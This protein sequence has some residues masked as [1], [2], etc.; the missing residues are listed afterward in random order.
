MMILRAILF[1]ILCILMVA[2][3]M[4]FKLIDI[5]SGN[6]SLPQSHKRRP[7]L[8][9]KLFLTQNRPKY[10][11][12]SNQ[13]SLPTTPSQRPVHIVIFTVWVGERLHEAKSNH[14]LYAKKLG[15]DYMHIFATPDEYAA[16]LGGS[17]LGWASVFVAQKLL[18]QLPSVD[19]FLKMDQ[20]CVFARAD[21]PIETI[22]D[23]REQ[24]HL[25]VS[26]TLP[27]SRFT[28]SHTWLIR[29]SA[30]S[31]DFLREWL[32]YRTWGRCG[33]IAQEQGAFHFA[34]GWSFIQAYPNNVTEFTCSKYCG[35]PRSSYKH[36]HCVLDWY[37]DNGFGMSG[38]FSH[39]YVFLYTLQTID[40][41][42]SPNDGYTLQI[43]HTNY[44]R[45]QFASSHWTPLTI[46]PC[47][48]NFYLPPRNASQLVHTCF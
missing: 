12:V 24:Y 47:K 10:P 6:F 8:G 19:Y 27:D 23:P 38:N 4:I 37:E 48:K 1:A 11:L 31:L 26:Q 46:H 2:N 34:L 36:H 13:S 17:P 20:D 45:E 41:F 18:Q 9:N 35:S 7:I 16:V 40:H 22:I 43:D 25:Y 15:Y 39:P 29:N 33:D 21:L 3:C 30:Y 14:N 32:D 5:A 28:Q 44:T 42:H